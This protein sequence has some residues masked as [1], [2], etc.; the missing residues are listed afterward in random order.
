MLLQTQTTP[1]T[2]P[3]RIV[4]ADDHP[5]FIEGFYAALRKH[6]QVVIEGNASNGAELVQM[7]EELEPDVVF[8]D[9]QMPVMDGIEATR[10]I[11]QRFPQIPVIAY[12]GF[13][14]DCFI[15]DMLEAGA[16]GYLLKNDSVKEVLNAI[17]KVL[18]GQVY[19]NLEVSNRLVTLMK[20]ADF[21]PRRPFERPRFSQVEL[22]VIRETC[23]GLSSKEIANKLGIEVRSVETAKSRI[24]IKAGC[25]NSAGIVMFAIRNNLVEP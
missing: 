20:R 11:K 1:R 18:N 22:S 13:V 5:I 24:L 2:N 23:N 17:D 15:T 16:S 3:V 9:I 10:K 14:E 19:W 6:T 25:R 4:I 12:S 8:T 7:V 21:N